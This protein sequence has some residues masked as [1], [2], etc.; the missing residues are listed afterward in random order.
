MVYPLVQHWHKFI[1][2]G[3]SALTGFQAYSHSAEFNAWLC[4]L[5]QKP[6]VEYAIGPKRKPTSIYFTGWT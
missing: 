2:V 1:R 5:N 4:K 3:H 6:T